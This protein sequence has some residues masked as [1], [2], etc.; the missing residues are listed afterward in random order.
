MRLYGKETTMSQ[1][2]NKSIS[3]VQAANLANNWSTL[4]R[5]EKGQ[6]LKEL[7]ARGCSRRGLAERTGA[8]ETIVRRRVDP[9]NLF[10][11]EREAVESGKASVKGGWQDLP[12][13]GRWFR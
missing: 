5:F 13:F 9:A 4:L 6:R 8:S 1:N 3:D 2:D 7:V 10:L 11:A 12:A